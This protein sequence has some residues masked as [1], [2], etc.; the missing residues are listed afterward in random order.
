MAWVKEFSGISNTPVTNTLQVTVPAGGVPA[1]HFLVLGIA[2]RGTGT[3]TWAVTDS[4]SNTWT[5]NPT[6]G[7]DLIGATADGGVMATC[8]VATTLLAGDTITM[9][10]STGT[11]D[12]I[13][14]CFEEFDDNVT[15][16]AAD[17]GSTNDNGGAQG[18]VLT[19]GTFN[20]TQ[21][22]E[23]LIGVLNMVSIG[24]V[25]T[26]DAPWTAGT[27][28]ATSSGSGDRAVV[29]VWRTVSSTGTYAATGTFNTSAF[30]SFLAAGYKISTTPRTGYAKVWDGG[31]WV[32]HPAKVWNG[33]AWVTHKMRGWD[34]SGWTIGK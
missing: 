28:I 29:V 12:R 33:S 15:Q 9:T 27:K 1:G 16:V 34:G 3:P 25:F 13:A 31:A 6:F 17:A 19:S 7:T 20:T 26:Q 5:I 8:V 14:A 2:H 24:R 32:S 23:L 22:D 21:N 4:R 30:Y 11:I 18:N 10:S